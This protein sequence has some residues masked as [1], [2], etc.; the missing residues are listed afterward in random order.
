MH[1]QD[2]RAPARNSCTIVTIGHYERLCGF[3]CPGNILDFSTPGCWEV[4]ARISDAS[5]TF[6]ANVVKIG[7]GLQRWDPPSFENQPLPR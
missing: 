5:L 3:R 1:Y 4:A 2:Y 7:N 6:V